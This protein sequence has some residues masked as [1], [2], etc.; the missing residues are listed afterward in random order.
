[1]SRRVDPQSIEIMRP[2]KQADRNPLVARCVVT[3]LKREREG[4]RSLALLRPEILDFWYEKHTAGELAERDSVLSQ[5]QA[6][7][8]MFSPAA[9]LLPTRTCPYSFHYRYRDDDGEHVGTCQDWET[10]QTYFVRLR[11]QGSEQ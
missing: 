7:G 2:L 10:E 9:S 11:D 1:E 4:N 8:D 6:Q 3:S 5:L